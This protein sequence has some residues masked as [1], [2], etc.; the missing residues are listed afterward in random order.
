MPYTEME[1]QTPN[2]LI[3]IAERAKREPAFQFVS[4]AHLLDAGYLKGS[5][6][7]LGR[8]R[9]SGVDGVS[10]QKYGEDL[11]KNLESLVSRMK[12]KQYKPQPVRRVWIPK[13]GGT[14]RPLGLP[15]LEDKVVQ[16]GLAQI[17]GII[18]EQDFLNCSYGFRPNRGCHDALKEMDA[19]IM[20][21]P[22]NF[23]V[24]TDIKGYFDHVPHE[25]M[26]EFLGRRIKDPSFLLLVR[27]FLKAGYQEDGKLIATETGV[28]Q[29]GNLSPVLSN[30]FLHYV[31]DEWFEK[32]IKPRLKGESHL[33][34]Y[35]DD[36]ICMVEKG[37]EAQAIL[38]ALRE[39]FFQHGLEL[40]PDKTRC[41]SFGRKESEKA[42]Q[43]NRKPSTFDF[44]GFTFY[45]GKSRWG[46]FKLGIKTSKKKY[47]KCLREMNLWLKGVRNVQ[48]AKEWWPL[49]KS[50]LRGHYQYYG[51][52]GNY[53]AISRYYQQTQ[54]MMFKWLNRR[55]QCKSFSA[56]TF[57]EYL[58]RYS[59]P[60]PR[61]VHSFYTLLLAT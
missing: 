20:K 2:K 5:Y 8:D 9:A 34:R 27:R 31:L 25:K 12:A 38:S 49:V 21:R 40:H 36:F 15:A 18:Y 33:V 39:R 7:E 26:M 45:C 61:I 23:V 50:K 1:T 44:L 54:W 52:S 22:I 53:L 11:E 37:E 24:E 16:R 51:V 10:W 29:G 43:E 58:K 56:E 3:L 47:R 19:L 55:S 28:P 42:K 57:F 32:E 35:A 14:K 41:F 13:E 48:T 30:I 6:L 4:L 60:K 59:L 17:L 46:N